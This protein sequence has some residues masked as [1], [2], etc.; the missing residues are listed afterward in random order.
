[1]NIV[2]DVLKDFGV[3]LYAMGLTKV[4]MM[5]EIVAL[6]ERAQQKVRVTRDNAA[7]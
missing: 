6:L 5:P 1:M 7:I 4:F 3:D 2:K